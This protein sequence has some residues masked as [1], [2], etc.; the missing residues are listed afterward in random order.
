MN[1][2]VENIGEVVTSIKD[3]AEQTNLLA[4]NATIEAARAGE[5]GKGFAVVAD[6]VKKLANETGQKTEEIENRITEIQGATH[7]SVEV[8]QRIIGNISEIDQ[9]VTGVSAAVEEQNATTGEIVRSVSEA[10]QGVQQVS[11]IIIEVQKGAG[12]TGISA[13]SVLTAAKEVAELSD[14]LKGSIDQFL[15]QIR[16]D[17]VDQEEPVLEAAE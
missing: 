17:N 14:N 5:A 2:L 15:D 9:S 16:N 7:A 1:E 8:M 4:L 3:I 6:E 11:Q 13:D 12:E 10:S